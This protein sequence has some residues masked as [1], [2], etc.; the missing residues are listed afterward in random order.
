MTDEEI[1]ALAEK[2]KKEKY[3]KQHQYI[4]D[5]YPC[6]GDCPITYEGYECTDL[7]SIPF[8]DGF[9]AAYDK[10]NIDVNKLTIGEVQCAIKQ[11]P[12]YAELLLR[13]I[14]VNF[15]KIYRDCVIKKNG[16]I[17]K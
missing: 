17:K 8:L 2:T 9:K 14:G 16:K 5:G 12:Q 11:S 15:A 7:Y 10:I 13:A 1:I 4:E 3:C 6:C